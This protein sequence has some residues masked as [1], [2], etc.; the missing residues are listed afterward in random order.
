MDSEVAFFDPI[1]A[2]QTFLDHKSKQKGKKKRKTDTGNAGSSE[3]ETTTTVAEQELESLRN[4]TE[5]SSTD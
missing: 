1:E 2:E 4:S 3:S 5:D